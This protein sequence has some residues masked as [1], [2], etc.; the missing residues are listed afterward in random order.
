MEHPD[1][2]QKVLDGFM[3][4]KETEGERNMREMKSH[5]SD[6][7][8][9]VKAIKQPDINITVPEIKIPKIVVPPA[10]ITVQERPIKDIVVS[11]FST[12]AE[13][14]FKKLDGIIE[15]KLD[16]SSVTV[17]NPVPV[18]LVHDGKF[19]KAIDKVLGMAGGHGEPISK[20]QGYSPEELAYEEVRV[21]DH[22]LFTIDYMKAIGLGLIPGHS[23]ITIKGKNPDIDNIREDIW[24][25]GG[26]Y[27][28]PSDAGISMKISS[29]SIS[30]TSAGTGARTVDVKY[31]RVGFIE[32]TQ[33]VTLNG[34][35]PVVLTH[36]D[37]IRIN[38]LHVMTAG[39]T[40]T[41]VGNISLVDNTTGLITYGY[42]SAGLNA[43]RQ[44]IYTVPVG[45]TLFITRW[46][47]HEGASS[48]SHFTE[49]ILRSTTSEDGELTPGVFHIRS[50]V[51]GDNFIKCVAQSDIK[52]ST[53]SDAAN[54]NVGCNAQINGWIE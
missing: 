1:A 50:E 33:T 41:A 54:A 23:I 18:Q 6:I 46:D 40:G 34:T 53:I 13:G 36:T 30:D 29:S 7:I 26:I 45:K 48:G 38:G 19:Y 15:K 32:A 27:A 37:I 2:V 10:N 47:I 35:T 20:L 3:R 8:N 44:C 22:S 11:G 12:F 51:T 49:S 43:S 9:A 14:L 16:F 17:D 52:I 42:I 31:L 5:H 39:S 21:V 4:F 28:F 24:E 25:M